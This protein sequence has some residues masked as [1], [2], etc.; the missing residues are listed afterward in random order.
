MLKPV[1]MKYIRALVL[2]RDERA[3]LRSLGRA[4]VVQLSSARADDAAPIAAPD[5]SA[6]IARCDALVA[7]ADELLKGFAE[8]EA[9]TSPNALG[10]G[11]D[12]SHLPLGEIEANLARIAQQMAEAGKR[13]AEKSSR[14]DSVRA[15]AE[16][17]ESFRDVNLPFSELGNFSFLHFSIGSIPTDKVEAL[18]DAVAGNVV[19]LPLPRAGARTAIVAATSRTGRFALATELENA[20]FRSETVDL[21]GGG[22]ISEAVGKARGELADASAA[23]DEANLVRHGIASKFGPEVRSYRAAALAEKQVLEAESRFSR[24]SQTVQLQ[25]WAP[26]NDAQGVADKIRE[27][28]D[29]R[30][31]VEILDPAQV[32]DVPVPVLLRHNWFLRPFEMLV[33]GYGM[34]GYN[35]LEPTLFVAI[36][37][38]LMFGMMFGD[39]G[40][41]LVLVLAGLAT[42]LTAK[43]GKSR[44]VGALVAMAGGASM[45]FGA[46]YGSFF[47]LPS[48]QKFAL[49]KEPL[50]D[51]PG[52]MKLAVACGVLVISSGIVLN[53]VNRIRKG[54]WGGAF[55]SGFGVVGALFYWG[56]LGLA[57]KTLATNKSCFSGVAV[58]LVVVV[59]LVAWALYK[60]VK[61]ALSKKRAE[62]EGVGQSFME[63]CI[64]TFENVLS[65]M[66]NTISFVRLAAYALSHAAVLMATFMMADGV[67]KVDPTGLG[68][69]F[70]IIAGN[71]LAIVLE[72]MVAAI[73]AL[74]LEYYEFFGKFFAGDGEE[75]KPFKV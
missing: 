39:V 75:F 44:D 22:T 11:I 35:E 61:L 37:Y 41:G 16:Q 14:C 47:G 53:V 20:G 19:L 42:V 31:V 28:T 40:H 57:I 69:L 74:R 55:F 3:V 45:L 68:R 59:P 18:N 1:R 34:P 10:E 73:Q 46:V 71:A 65:Y 50:N 43:Q 66:A 7:S 25:G 63:A 29:G 70:V 9:P 36:T 2:S 4:G 54:D 15:V 52:I 30:S 5:N 72:G 24:T 26:E 12:V 13:V 27:V 58:A 32:P 17:L 64:G 62:G 67:S 49:W 6:E 21:A 48:F 23:L 56:V 60:P 38:L 8:L 33:A 51:A